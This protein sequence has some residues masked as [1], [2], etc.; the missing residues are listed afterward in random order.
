[1]VDTSMRSQYS[2]TEAATRSS[3]T[4]LY[5]QVGVPQCS[6]INLQHPSIGASRRPSLSRLALLSVLGGH[7]W[8]LR[9]GFSIPKVARQRRDLLGVPPLDQ[10]GRLVGSLRA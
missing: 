6:W 4:S 8:H 10:I 2:G 9:H 1:M 5:F 7:L 3:L